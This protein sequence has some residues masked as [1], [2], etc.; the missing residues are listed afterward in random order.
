[1]HY[2]DVYHAIFAI[3]PFLIFFGAVTS[4]LWTD[5]STQITWTACT[6]I[7]ILYASHHSQRE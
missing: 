6:I 7:I 2:S 1:M 4:V 3:M 5:N